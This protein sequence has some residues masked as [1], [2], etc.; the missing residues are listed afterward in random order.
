[1]GI[2]LNLIGT[3][4]A[5]EADEWLEQAALWLEGHEEEPLMRCRFGTS[6]GGE[7]VLFVQIHRCAEDVAISIPQP[8]TVSVLAK[9]STAGPGY[10]IFVCELLDKLGAH[11]HIDWNTDGDRRNADAT[12]YFFDR[13]AGA[14]RIEMLRWLAALARVIADSE[15][16]DVGLRMVAMP[17]D[18]SYPAQSGVLTPMGPREP[19]WFVQVI[20]SPDAGIDFFPW[21]EE[22]AGSAFFLGRALCCLWQDVRWRV[23]ITEAE[24]EMLM[25]VHLDLERA[26]HLDANASIPWRDWH[27]IV[28]FLH[29]YFGYAEF[30]HED[31]DEEAIAERAKTIDP[32]LAPI[33]YRRGPVEVML[34]GGWKITIP[35]EFA[36]EWQESGETWSAWLGGRTIWF[37]SWSVREAGDKLDAAEILD[38]QVDPSE[39]E[40]IEHSAGAV[41]GR[42]VFKP[43]E[44]DGQP[45]W[46]LMAYSVAEGSFCLCN[47]YIQSRD[48]LAWAVEV[49]KT[50]SN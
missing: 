38:S 34:T 47:I 50:L 32:N 17:L 27:E 40:V 19:A 5:A 13:D 7:P 9:T 26:Y 3:L 44:E 28:G 22:G 36:E 42:A 37:T 16:D 49:W 48:D 23:P 4:P 24:G 39:G 21:W 29:D 31:L 12:G 46:N 45:A 14:V 6:S 10:H 1:M 20:H 2:A 43:V 25:D 30:H 8:G 11:F 18:C 41:V 15:N 35:G 33:G